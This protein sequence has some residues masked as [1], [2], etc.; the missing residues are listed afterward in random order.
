MGCSHVT[1]SSRRPVRAFESNH[2]AQSNMRLTVTLPHPFAH[3]PARQARPGLR[4]G[5]EALLGGTACLVA[6]ARRQRGL[7]RV[8]HHVIA[9]AQW[10]AVRGAAA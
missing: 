5:E 7:A 2:V 3:L 4:R 8:A 1:M 6:A 10:P 9:Q